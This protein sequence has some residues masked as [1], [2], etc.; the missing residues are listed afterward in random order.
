MVSS[1]IDLYP[2]AAVDH[3]KHR[4]GAQNYRHPKSDK[5]QK[6]FFPHGRLSR[7]REY[8]T[9]LSETVPDRRQHGH[10][11]HDSLIIPAPFRAQGKQC[12]QSSSP[13]ASNIASR[14]AR[15]F[16]SSCSRRKS[17]P[18]FPSTKCCSSVKATVLA[19]GRGDKVKIFKLRRRKHYQKTQ[20]HRQSY[21]EVRVDDI[22]QG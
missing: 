10:E 5:P 19:H 7:G 13:A 2:G 14:P 1:E 11:T 22:V 20:G 6:Q 16:A 8:V 18:R 12:T 9:G 17:A 15:S 4:G 3:L 21:T